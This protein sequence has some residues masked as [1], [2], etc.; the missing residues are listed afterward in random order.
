MKKQA[1]TKPVLPTQTQGFMST[2]VSFLNKMQVNN[3]WL[4][5][6]SS[7]MSPFGH[8]ANV[9]MYNYDPML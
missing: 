3:L 7:L 6:C 8:T 9:A 4:T 5:L 2:P 1:Q